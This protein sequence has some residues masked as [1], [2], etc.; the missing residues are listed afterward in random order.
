MAHFLASVC[1]Q[2]VHEIGVGLGECQQLGVDL[3]RCHF[4]EAL[5]G[6]GF[7]AHRYPHICVDRVS[8]FDRYFGVI[9]VGE[10]D[11]QAVGFQCIHHGLLGLVAIRAGDNDFHAEHRCSQDPGIGHVAGAVSEE[12]DFLTFECTDIHAIRRVALE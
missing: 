6:F 4:L 9:C 11:W 1:R 8:V 5:L 3:I 12:S 2:T 10:V 7:V